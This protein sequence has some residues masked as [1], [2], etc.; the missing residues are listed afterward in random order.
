MVQDAF[1]AAMKDPDFIAE[2]DHYH[3][4]L[5]PSD[6]AQLEAFVKDLRHTKTDHRP[7]REI[8]SIILS[9]PAKPGREPPE[10]VVEGA[11]DTTHG[12]RLRLPLCRAAPPPR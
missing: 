5:D 3:L 6:G 11:P 10:G 12:F 7:D 4:A 9:C 1:A 2:T 8:D